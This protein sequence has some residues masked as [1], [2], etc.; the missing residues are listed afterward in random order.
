MPVHGKN[1]QGEDRHIFE[2]ERQVLPRL[3]SRGA[4]SGDRRAARFLTLF[5][6]VKWG[7]WQHHLVP[8]PM[9][10]SV[11]SAPRGLSR[12][13]PLIRVLLTTGCS[14]SALS[15]TPSEVEL[16]ATSNP[17]AQGRGEPEEPAL[18]S[19]VSTNP[20]SHSLTSSVSDWPHSEWGP[21]KR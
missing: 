20:Y 17:S 19:L 14:G 6:A 2:T 16:G 18:G 13:L 10:L 5:S 3:L 12:W 1:L 15:A 9:G 8:L 21:S 7:Q 11:A 4:S